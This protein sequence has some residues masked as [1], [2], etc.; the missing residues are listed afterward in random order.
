M[1]IVTRRQ[2]STIA[3]LA[4]GMG[5]GIEARVAATLSAEYLL[6][7]INEGFTNSEAVRALLR[8]L[9]R[10][11]LKNGPWAAL[12]VVFITSSGETTA[13]SYESPQPFIMTAHGLESPLFQLQHWDGEVIGEASTHLRPN[14]GLLLYSDGVSQAGLG[15]G[16]PRGWG[17]TG[18]KLYLSGAGL[19]LPVH[20]AAIPAALARKAASFHD[21]RPADDIT[22]LT[23][24]LRKPR[25]LHIL[26]GPPGQ[27]SD[28]DKVM[29]AFLAKEGSKVVCGGTTTQL[30]AKHMGVTPQVVPGKFGA[31][32]HY[33]LNGIDLASE[34][35]VTLN[36]ANNIFDTPEYAP[37]AG[38][39]VARLLE[40]LYEADEVHFWVGQ[41]VNPAHSSSLKPVGILTRNEVV[42]ELI[43]KLQG[44]KKLAVVKKL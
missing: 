39:G 11:K 10:A 16:Y 3:I 22:V 12:N 2:N 1:V 14:E 6:S 27:R 17:E 29:A 41:A 24:A 20:A 5:S 33:E 8:S 30:L 42:A 26:T 18:I 7:L 35:T 25:I 23:L 31:P 34:G 37:E 9:R 15:R 19:N 21:N 43:E 36:R 44:A 38:Y 4:D 40:L 13:Y 28:T 32:A